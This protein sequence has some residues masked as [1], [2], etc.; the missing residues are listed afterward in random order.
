MFVPRFKAELSTEH[1]LFDFW[2]EKKILF[3]LSKTYTFFCSKLWTPWTTL[4]RCS[5]VWTKNRHIFRDFLVLPNYF[6]LNVWLRRNLC[7]TLFALCLGCSGLIFILFLKID[8]SFSVW[9]IRGASSD[10][11]WPIKYWEK[12]TWVKN[13]RFK[14]TF[15]NYFLHDRYPDVEF[16]GWK[17]NGNG[18][19]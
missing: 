18:I 5:F 17:N 12:T 1:N 16:Y 19:I 10:A 9:P 6:H 14:N 11:R 2:P 8:N 3:F 15:L 13:I 4:V 7:Q